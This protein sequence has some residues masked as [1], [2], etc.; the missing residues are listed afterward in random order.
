[1]K[2]HVYLILNDM[3]EK[4]KSVLKSDIFLLLKSPTAVP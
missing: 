2:T 3:M 4:K 1:M